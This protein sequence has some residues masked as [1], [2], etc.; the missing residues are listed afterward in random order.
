MPSI[1]LL[2]QLRRQPH[3]TR[4]V[5]PNTLDTPSLHLLE[6]ANQHAIRQ[7]PFHQLSR[8][9][10]ARRAGRAGVVGVVDGDA[11]HAELVEDALAG[12]RVAV[13]VAGDAGVDVVVVE[14]GVEQGF[15]AGF[16]A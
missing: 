15:G 14:L 5:A 4:P 1:S 12:R 2:H 3:R 6:A 13:A 10:Q 9:V 7:P 11:G 8:E 16:Q